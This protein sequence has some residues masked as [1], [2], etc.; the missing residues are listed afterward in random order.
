MHTTG[1][2]NE[3]QAR[4][5]VA[6]ELQI[7]SSPNYH[8]SACLGNRAW[9]TFYAPRPSPHRDIP[10]ERSSAT[11]AARGPAAAMWLGQ[12]REVYQKLAGVWSPGTVT[13]RTIPLDGRSTLVCSRLAHSSSP[14]LFRLAL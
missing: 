13:V 4:T 3:E 10:G 12:W 1:W 9:S 6:D 8:L 7:A 14:R 11:C 5:S 2:A